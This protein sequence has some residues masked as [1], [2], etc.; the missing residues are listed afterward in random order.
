MKD[1]FVYNIPLRVTVNDYVVK[2]NLVIVKDGKD[3]KEDIP[4]DNAKKFE[5][6]SVCGTVFVMLA[7]LFAVLMVRKNA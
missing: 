2:D 4:G 5:I 6:P 7:T 3:T 1:G